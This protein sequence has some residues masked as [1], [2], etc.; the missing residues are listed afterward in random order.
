MKK[1]E[2]SAIDSIYEV[3]ERIKTV[4]K[5]YELLNKQLALMNNKLNK[6]IAEEPKVLPQPEQ[7]PFSSTYTNVATKDGESSVK[8]QVPEKS[9]GFVIGKVKV[10]SRILTPAKQPIPDVN[11]KVFS[12]DNKLL[13]N[14]LTDRDGYWDAR[15]PPGRYRLTMDHSN[16]KTIERS[17]VLDKSMT[18]FEVK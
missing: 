16:F 10:F 9:G 13:R 12:F 2:L 14:V 11:I 6:I 17:I 1:R 7:R 4:E 15:L 8:E 18:S 3:L 5:H